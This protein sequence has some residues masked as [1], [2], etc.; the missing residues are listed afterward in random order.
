MTKARNPLRALRELQPALDA[1]LERHPDYPDLRNLRGLART[2]LGDHQ[3]AFADFAEALRIHRHYEAALLNVAW[4]HAQR[5]EPQAL[6]A[7]LREPRGRRLRPVQRIHLHMLAAH[8]D[9]G[10][11][12]ALQVLDTHATVHSSAAD[13]WLELDRLWLQW[14]LG[15]WEA[16]DQQVRRLVAW[17]PSI[18][19]LLRQL[20]LVGTPAEKRAAFAVW[21]DCYRGN[22]NVAALLR[23]CARLRAVSADGPEC[24]SI[25]RWSASL[26][27]DLC[28]YWLGVGEQYDLEARDAEAETAFRQ[29]SRFA[30]ERAQPYIKLG[31]LFA[32]CGRPQEAIRELQHAAGLQPRYADVRYLLGLLLEDLGQ[33]E[34]AEGHLR[35][36]LDVNPNYTMARLALGY[37]LAARGRER[38]ALKHLEHVRRD[39]V[40]SADL[41]TRLAILYEHFGRPADAER[42]RARAQDPEVAADNVETADARGDL[43]DSP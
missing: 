6:H 25:L 27:L 17:I 38:D 24:Q 35:T 13:P 42:A 16:L 21:G 4:L 9:V 41:E 43:D 14:Q 37:L 32:V 40:V 36:A 19:P 31:Q 15:R 18:G 20:G 5:R 8:A 30:P 33:V 3:G 12:S 23:E 2:Y 39:G 29:A 26:S 1:R 10:A 22:P 34:E 28:D 11:E 7:I